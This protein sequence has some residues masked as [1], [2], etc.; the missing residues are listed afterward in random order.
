MLVG[1]PVARRLRGVVRG[2]VHALSVRSGRLRVQHVHARGLRG[3][4][5]PARLLLPALLRRRGERDAAHHAARHHGAHRAGL[6]G[7]RLLRVAPPPPPPDPGHRARGRAQGA[8]GRDQ[9]AGALHRLQDDPHGPQMRMTRRGG[10]LGDVFGC[11]SLII[12][13]RSAGGEH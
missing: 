4:H 3:L 2:R 11:V 6:A 12:L 5:E 13:D 9:G 1:Q 8:G 7:R 10:R